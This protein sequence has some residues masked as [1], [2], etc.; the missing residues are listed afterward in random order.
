MPTDA[1]VC[2]DPAERV[3]FT[4]SSSLFR[5]ARRSR[6]GATR[7]RRAATRWIAAHRSSTFPWASQSRDETAK[8][9]LPKVHRE[10]STRVR[11]L[12]VYRARTAELLAAAVQFL[13]RPRC[14]KPVRLSP[15]LARNAKSTDGRLAACRRRCRLD[16]RGRRF[17]ADGAVVTTFLAG[18]SRCGP[19]P[20]LA[21]C[22]GGDATQWGADV[23]QSPAWR[24]RDW[25]RGSGRR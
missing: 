6:P 24:R 5:A 21:S 25:P 14:S 15:V 2:T 7:L 20:S 16:R 4:G 17:Y 13:L 18:K 11:G 19:R 23:R 12:A 8:D 9:V 1:G 10:R 3:P 22:P